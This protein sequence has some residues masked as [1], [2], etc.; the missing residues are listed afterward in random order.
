MSQQL[1]DLTAEVTNATTVE[2]GA[3]TLIQNIA[4]QL[5]AAGTDPVKLQAL[6]DQLSTS[7]AALA[8][9]IT[10]NTPAAPTA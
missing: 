3:I 2:Q 9:A 4:A 1:D 8:A 10:A 6:K 7:D 5:A